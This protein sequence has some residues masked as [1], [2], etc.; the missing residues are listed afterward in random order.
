MAGVEGVAPAW[1]PT[2]THAALRRRAALL[3]SL[4]GHFA[5]SACLE[6][7]TPALTARA[8]SEPAL[9]SLAVA[10]DGAGAATC[11]LRTS[12]EAAMKRLLAA[13][14]GDIYQIGP[15]FRAD[16][17]GRHHRPEFTLLEWYRVGRDHHDMMDELTL[18]LGLLGCRRPV[19]RLAYADLFEDV[20]GVA[21]STQDTPALA[22]L[23]ADAG[24][25]LPPAEADD[26]A[27]VQDA[28]FVSRLEPRLATLGV[29]L[30]HD[31]PPE[32]R[33]YARLAPGGDTAQRFELVIDGLEI[34]NGYHEITDAAEQAA[35][36]AAERRVRAARALPDV[37]ADA[38]WLAALT[39]GLPACAGVA[40]GIERLHMALDDHADI[41]AVTCFADELV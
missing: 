12:P 30:L 9:G 20:F 10:G 39:A 32:Q 25:D 6:V 21:L 13:G 2:A 27:L 3:A 18:L 22:R 23:A 33:A 38:A 14:S 36:F 8:S 1:R 19:R 31:Y 40:L 5:A 37:P 24:I 17:S 7:S 11:F 4:R 28:L 16:E 26:R 41:A 35:C 15:A 29:V 34:A